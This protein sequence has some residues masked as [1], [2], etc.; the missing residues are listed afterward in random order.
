MKSRLVVIFITFFSI[1][2]IVNAQQIDSINTI[3]EEFNNI[4]SPGAVVVVVKNGEILHLNGYGNANLEY[5]IPITSKTIFHIGSVSKQFTAFAIILL[6]NKEK[7]SQN[8]YIGKYLTDLPDFKDSIKIKHLLH[9]T[10]GLREIEQLHQIAGIT[11]ADQ[12]ES[13][14]LYNLIKNQKDLNFTPGDELEYTNTNYFLLAKVVESISG[15]TFQ[16]WTKANIFNPLNMANT[17]FYDDCSDIVKNRAYAY[18]DWD[19]E[20]YKGILSYSYVG[21]TS[22]LTTGEDMALWLSNFS[23]IQL[24]NKEVSLKM[25]NVTDTLND[26]ELID[27]GSG[28]GVTNYKG[29]KVVLHSGH[30]A[31]YRAGMMYFPDHEVGIALLG[32]YYAISPYKYGFKIADFIL[33]DFIQEEAEKEKQVDSSEDDE[34]TKKYTM[35]SDKL[36]EYQGSY[37]SEELG[38]QYNLRVMNDTLK[39]TFWR[40]EDVLLDPIEVDSFEGNQYWFQQIKFN[41]NDSNAI[42]GFNL[43]SGKI[44][45]MKFRKVVKE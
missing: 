32:N 3:F 45:N 15:Q 22:V 4:N 13:T 7:L 35:T 18:G 20:L 25:L 42:I 12:I 19:G 1:I 5:E 26:G 34:E 14:F 44:R 39:A 41:R 2:N 33:K 9:H 21:P 8:D 17:Q 23:E 16:N 27:Y 31:N 11:T 28:L 40:N 36:L 30:D 38:V 10:S 37:I 43:S 24:G 6:E 29:L